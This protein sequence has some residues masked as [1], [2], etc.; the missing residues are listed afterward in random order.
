MSV[1]S[2]KSE[3]PLRPSFFLSICFV[4]WLVF[5]HGAW[6]IVI[7]VGLGRNN[8]HAI[9]FLVCFAPVCEE[10]NPFLCNTDDRIMPRQ[11]VI[12]TMVMTESILSFSFLNCCCSR[13]FT[14]YDFFFVLLFYG[15]YND[16]GHSRLAEWCFFCSWFILLHERS[17]IIHVR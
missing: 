3:I 14:N 17:S 5:G 9:F 12:T 15:I 7:F 11:A 4:R 2:A 16:C 1:F 8:S 6:C 13:S 10:Y